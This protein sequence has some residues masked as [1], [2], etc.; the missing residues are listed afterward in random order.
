[1]SEPKV[2]PLMAAKI[3]AERDELLTKHR[4]AVEVMHGSSGLDQSKL[5]DALDALRLA[6]YTI[7]APDCDRRYACGWDGRPI[8]IT[9]DRE[10]AQEAVDAALEQGQVGR[11][12]LLEQPVGPW[13]EAT[14]PEGARFWKEQR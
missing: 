12:S 7:L 14:K 9:E 3:A 10:R 8:G 6:G 13:V 2:G 5:G 1:M 11:W 4:R